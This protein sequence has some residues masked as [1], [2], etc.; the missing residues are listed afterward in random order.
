MKILFTGGGSGGH[1]YPIVAV[2]QAVSDIS[3]ERKLIGV[4]MHYLAPTPFDERALFENNITFHR[5]PAGKMR[6]YFSLLNI[7]DFF[8]TGWGIITTAWQVFTLYP[9]VIFSKG[10]YASF[11]TVIAAKL[12]RIPLVI[13]ESDAVPGRANIWAAKSAERIAVAFPESAEYFPKQFRDKIA[14][15]G[16]PIRRELFS[17]AKEGTH[18][19][20]K[21]RKDMP[22]ILVLGGS[23]GAQMI[24]DI[25]VESLPFLLGKYQVIHQTGKR[26][27][28]DVKALAEVVLEGHSD[29]QQYQPF[30]YL[31]ELALRMAAGAV[32]LVITRAGAG[33]LFEIAAWGL[34][35]III[36]I[37]DSNGD[38]QRK[39][40]YAYARQGTGIVIEEK[41]LTTN[42]LVSEIERI[43]ADDAMRS[44]MKEHA[45]SFSKQNAARTIA[46]AL[47]AISLKHETA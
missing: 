9:D 25:V 14:L 47:I 35:S 43:M 28:K 10:G 11:P 41:N 39:N 30:D 37:T 45:Q 32:D 21:L 40:A 19:Y 15:T 13:H 1:F 29:V 18:E 5:S 16:N 27:I 33:A 46:D 17:V 7:F 4:E 24:N 6:R 22:T 8:K 36:P 42:L 34:P 12:F 44:A 26:N 31:N 23:Q 2:A 38:H 3:R 20:L